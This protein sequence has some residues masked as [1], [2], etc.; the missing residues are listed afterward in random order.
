MKKI[1]ILSFL[2]CIQSFLFSQSPQGISYQAVVRNADGSIV[3]S[4]AVTITFMI[5]DLTASGSVVYQ[6]SHNATTNAQG[7][8]TCI[9][10]SGTVSMGSFNSINWGGGSKFLHVLVNF[11]SGNVDMGTQQMLSVPY[12]KYTESVG[13][14]ISAIGD[15][16]T[17]GQNSVIVPG[18]SASN[19]QGLYTAGNG[20][21][22]I[23]G[24]FYSSIIISGQ[25]WMSSNLMVSQYRNGDVIPAN[26]SASAWQGTSVGGVSNY[27]DL[28]ANV[29]IYGKLYN[30]YAV[31]DSR[32]ICPTGWHVPTDSEWSTLETALGG[33][34]GMKM[35]E[36]GTIAMGN[37][38]WLTGFEPATNESGFSAQPGGYRYFSGTYNGQT[39]WANF[40]ANTETGPGYAWDRE[41]F[42]NNSN[43]G[44]NAIDK[45]T[46]FS[47][48]C[49]KD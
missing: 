34:P 40:W 1:F 10:G 38:Q 3:Q 33:S 6:E 45:H 42:Y 27:D 39:A 11:G 31:N 29:S 47:V 18:I 15:T 8:V 13:F 23:N 28:S 35:K 48:R 12:A 24:N 20:V 4:S 14:R 44:R 21:T 30:W 22:D 32:G 36:A 43:L 37:G 2:V 19:P 26:L 7:L 5:H 25:E 9:V 46:G 49:L 41:L 16:L 17:I